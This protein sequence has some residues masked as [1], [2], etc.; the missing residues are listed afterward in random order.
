M[1]KLHIKKFSVFKTL[2]HIQNMK[3]MLH[4]TCILIKYNSYVKK[5]KI[6]IFRDI[7]SLI[8]ANIDFFVLE[9]LIREVYFRN[10][11]CGVSVAE[12]QNS[13]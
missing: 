3:Y 5:I 9:N 4:V 7:S 12:F 13:V 2:I 8:L 11:R 1:C 10:N 6:F